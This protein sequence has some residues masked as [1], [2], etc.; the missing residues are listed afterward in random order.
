MAA[1]PRAGGNRPAKKAPAKK[2][3]AAQSRP[4]IG[5]GAR[6]QRLA[7]AASAYV[8]PNI[9]S[10]T[11]I[12][13]T[14]GA[15]DSGTT[16]EKVARNE[17][18]NTLSLE[19]RQRYMNQTG[20]WTGGVPTATPKTTPKEIHKYASLP[21]HTAAG[22]YM[23]GTG[24][25]FTLGENGEVLGVK[26]YRPAKGKG[27]GKARTST[28][29]DLRGRDDG[30]RG[31]KGRGKRKGG[32][33]AGLAGEKAKEGK[34]YAEADVTTTSMLRAQGKAYAATRERL[35]GYLEGQ[36]YS[37]DSATEESAVVGKGRRRPKRLTK[38]A[39]R[40]NSPGGK[41]VTPKERARIQRAKKK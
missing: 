32:A 23:Y 24:G 36:T 26:S 31:P 11:P 17:F 41:K 18:L 12:G 7:A 25:E 38:K 9:A 37:P 14:P 20:Y 15:Y 13:V 8:S 34:S 5:G 40:P 22:T 28:T 39:K 4:G 35:G 30:R 27:K 33:G 29:S 16:L 19:D 3:P 6:G 10:D 2:K 1:K 21:G